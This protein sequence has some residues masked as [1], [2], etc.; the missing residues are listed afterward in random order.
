[1]GI[2]CKTPD[3]KHLKD[4][5]TTVEPYVTVTNGNTMM[6][7]FTERREHPRRKILVKMEIELPKVPDAEPKLLQEY[8]VKQ[9]AFSRNISEGGLLVLASS[10]ISPGTLIR[11]NIPIHEFDES[12]SLVG[13]VMRCEP[14]EMG[15]EIA[16]KFVNPDANDSAMISRY[17]AA[18]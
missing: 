17:V 6:Q 5:G 14:C 16:I 10:E 2:G 3:E 8:S 12:V 11:M 15:Y 1:M 7:P 4:H 18:G 13:K 9:P